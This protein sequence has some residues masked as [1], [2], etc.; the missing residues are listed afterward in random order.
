VSCE[1]FLK[2]KLPFHN[3]AEMASFFL[4]IHSPH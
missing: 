4:L 3:Q 1:F 2:K